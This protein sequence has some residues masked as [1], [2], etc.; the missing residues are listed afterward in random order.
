M[1]KFIFAAA[2]IVS[3]SAATD[4]GKRQATGSPATCTY[5]KWANNAN[6][7]I[8]CQLLSKLGSVCTPGFVAPGL[9]TATA[10]YG[11]P[12]GTSDNAC[13]CNVVAYN[14]AAACTWC[15]AGLFSTDWVTEKV[16]SAGCVAT[17][18]DPA[19]LPASVATFDTSV[20]AWA[21]LSN[22]GASWDSFTAAQLVAAANPTAPSSGGTP[23]STGK[24]SASRLT[25]SF[26]A[27]MGLQAAFGIGYGLW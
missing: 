21:L 3:V 24:S 14:L 26:G 2:T 8:P 20:P 5:A 22:K 7:E 23:N 18:Y 17:A 15:Q 13:F 27:Y 1:F 10:P 11:A 4:L 9:T 25:S 19:A 16:W 12:S 6:G